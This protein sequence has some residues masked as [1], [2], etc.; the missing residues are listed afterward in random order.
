M[1]KIKEEEEISRKNAEDTIEKLKQESNQQVC[2]IK[3][4]INSLRGKFP[5]APHLTSKIVWR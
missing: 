2:K 5:G 1:T 4:T 3:S